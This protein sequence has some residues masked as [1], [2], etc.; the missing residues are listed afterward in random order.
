MKRKH[1]EMSRRVSIL[2]YAL[3][4]LILFFSSCQ[5]E[6]VKPT[7]QVL[8]INEF[9]W[10][11][12]GEAYLWN[13][14][15]PQNIDRNKELDPEAYFQKLLY[16]PADKWSFITDD[17][18]E[19]I[20][21]LKGI[22]KT[23]GH[24]FKLYQ[25]PNSNNIIGIIKYVIPNS[26]AAL[27][28]IYRGDI[29][30]K[31][32]GQALNTENFRKLLFESEGYTMSFG[33]FNQNG[34]ISFKK[35]K[36]LNAIIVAENPIHIRN[37]IEFEGFKIGYLSYNQ[38]I[39][40][41]NDSLVNAFSEFQSEGIQDLVLDLRYNPGGSVNAAI[42]LSSLI[43]PSAVVEN[44]EVFSRLIWNDEVTEYLIDNEGE[45][46]NNLISRFVNPEV[47]LNLERV[48]ILISSNSASAS[49]LIINCLDPYMEVILIGSENT[50]GKYVGSITINDTEANHGWALQPIV[51]K[52][53]NAIG[54]SD[55]SDGFT[56]DYRIEDDFDDAL[57]AITEDMLAKAIELITGI[58][59]L[60][61]VRV[62]AKTIPLDIQPV[63]YERE[64][65]KKNMYFNLSK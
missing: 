56:P 17:Y 54:N 37:T 3:L 63:T 41:Y 16:K 65:Q 20:N 32:N 26:P 9:I 43:A 51:L 47:N 52:T 1:K 58:N 55:Y 24:K 8:E 14:F 18:D 2:S 13:D 19:L 12:M 59:I 10:K 11:N 21:S 15:I 62:G 31:V 5:K 4:I 33:E 22:E 57:G 23:Y 49:E 42:L 50:T 7:P 61:N 60:E 39:H 53:A 44:K 46:S 6:D 27:A 38:F 48:Y 30:Y 34:E 40:D 29:F 35:D 36:T 28:E 64:Q 25:L 45:E